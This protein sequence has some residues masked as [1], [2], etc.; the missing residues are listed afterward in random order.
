[1]EEKRTWFKPILREVLITLA[2]A[3]VIFILLQVTIQSSI[4]LYSSM[5][6]N[7]HEGQRIIISKTAYWFGEPKRGDIIVFPNP[8]NPDEEYIKRIIGM[9]DERVE[10]IGGVVYIRQVNGN[11][12]VLDESEYIEDP[13]NDDYSGN[14][15][16]E[17]EYFVLGDNRNN[18]FDSRRGWTVPRDEIVGKAWLS[19]WPL[20][21]W[22]WVA[23]YSFP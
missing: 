21:D 15:I 17:N 4:V 14:T 1:M 13:A 2:I 19:I 8:N 20:S 6:P 22:G 12:L 10:I 11:T 18:S 9:P 23:N 5:E 16:L 3:I 7:L